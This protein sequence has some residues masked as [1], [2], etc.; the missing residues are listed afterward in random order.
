MSKTTWFPP[1]TAGLESQPVLKLYN[2]LTRSKVEFVPSDPTKVSWY[3]CGPTVYNSSHMGHARNYVTIDI[4]RRI[5]QNYFNYDVLFVQNVTDIDDKIILQARQEYLFKQFAA[6]LNGKISKELIEKASNAL[7]EYILDKLPEF[8]NDRSEFKKWSDSLNLKELGL[9]KPKL[10]MYVKAVNAALEV[11]EN[12]QNVQLDLFL[13]KTKDVIVPVLDAELGATVTDPNIFRECSSYWERQY[14]LD[15]QKLNVLPPTVVTRVSEYIPEIVEY[16]KTIVEQGYAYAT[17]DGSVYFNT[18]KFDNA[19]NHEYAKCQPWSK[20]DMELLADGEGSLTNKSAL[21]SKLNPSDFALWKSS[22]PGEPFWDSPWG[23][24]RPGWHIECSVMASDF[25]GENMD[26]HSGGIDLAFP[27]HDNEL[28][29]SE[30]HYDCKQ[31]VNYFLHT[32]HLHIEG[33]KMSKSLKNF[34]TIDE[35]LEKFSARQLR[36]CFALV[37]W[38]NP[39]DFK[40]SLLNETKSVESTLDKFFSKI[41]AM[42]SDNEDTLAKGVIISKKYGLLE[43]KLQGEFSDAKKNVH[44]ALCDNLATPIAIRSL[45]ELVN[46][47]NTYISEAGSEIRIDS[48]IQ[49]VY[50]LTKMLN[51]FG[52]ETRSDNLGWKDVVKNDHLGGASKEEI[53]MP[54]V[55]VLSKFRDLVRKTSIEKGEYKILL[56]ACDKVRDFDLLDLGVA[57]DDRVDQGALV[58]FLNDQEKEE[59]LKQ[60]REKEAVAEMK[61]KKKEQQILLAAQKEKERVEKAKLSHVDMFKTEQYKSQ[62]SEWDEEGMPVKTAEGEE[63]SKSAKKKLAKLHAQQKKLHEEYLKSL[64]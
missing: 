21:E 41:R 46:N 16:V 56:D 30:A 28:A 8:T 19:D 6:T 42:K 9:T 12:S 5:L 36:L 55:K 22:K 54:F 38:N 51:I 1:Q 62:F 35:A 53:G 11:I 49:V 60:Q 43:K 17:K 47:S 29:Q 48:L 27:H 34:I 37:Q 61:R 39:L 58:K 24:G 20:G 23:Q 26:I 2:S 33:Q 10:P 45:M 31:W 59:L 25:V 7:D 50:Y 3:S 15:M 40:E 64:S 14:D 57:L 63:V 44:A 18:S 52:F 13:S 32:G 4:N